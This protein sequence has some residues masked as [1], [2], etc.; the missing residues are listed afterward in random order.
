MSWRREWLLTNSTRLPGGTVNGLGPT[1]PSAEMVM[2]NGWAPGASS[3][4]LPLL[5]TK[6]T[7]WPTVIETAVG[8]IAPLLPTV[9]VAPL[10]PGPVPDGVVGVPPPPPSSL[11]AMA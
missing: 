3:C 11:Q 8:L 7:L 9:T 6:V 4:E 10:G 5:L 1:V 2:V